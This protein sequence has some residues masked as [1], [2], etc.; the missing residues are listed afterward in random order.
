MV[1]PRRS[2]SRAR[3]A[4]PIPVGMTRELAL[5]GKL[6]ERVQWLLSIGAVECVAGALLLAG[7]ASSPVG[8]VFG[9][10][11][12]MAGPL[13]L[14]WGNS[15]RL[16]KQSVGIY[17]AGMVFVI[18]YADV[19]REGLSTFGEVAGGAGLFLGACAFLGGLIWWRMLP[20][21]RRSLSATPVDVRL[22][23]MVRRGYALMPSMAAQLWPSDS[24]SSAVLAQLG[25]QWSWPRYRAVDKLPAQVYGA[26][27]KGA[28]V[29]V[30]CP[31]TVLV[32]RIRWSRFGDDRPLRPM[33]PVL[34]WL[35]KERRLP[36]SRRAPGRSA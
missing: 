4:K 30:S 18:A 24:V 8:A 21:A 27:T 31:E 13:A 28:V 17:L 12:V 10:A 5:L 22:E 2:I 19:H 3:P 25:S 9:A 36:L 29:V 1:C 34:A 32:G 16:A 6:Q 7:M 15:E 23:V 11:M 35:M 20:A 14:L 26:P 33:P